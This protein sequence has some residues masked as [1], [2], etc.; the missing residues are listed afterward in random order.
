MDIKMLFDNYKYKLVLINIKS[1]KMS[2][3]KKIIDISKEDLDNLFRILRYF[4]NK[5]NNLR[6]I[7][8]ISYSI[9]I[10]D[11]VEYEGNSI[12]N[13]YFDYLNDWLGDINGR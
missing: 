13:S 3:D 2:I 7:D 5:N 11:K 9:L 10:D 4:D 8:S 1:L 12:S 6:N